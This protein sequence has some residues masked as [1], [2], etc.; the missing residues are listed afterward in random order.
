MSHTHDIDV[1]KQTSNDDH[2]W[3]SRVNLIAN[4][5]TPVFVLHETFNTIIYYYSDLTS[6]P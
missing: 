4:Q 5:R 3:M 6:Y 1:T 2:C